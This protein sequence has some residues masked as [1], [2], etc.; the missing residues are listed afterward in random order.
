[1]KYVTPIFIKK[2]VEVQ[3]SA[4]TGLA[5]RTMRK[6]DQLSLREIARRMSITPAYLCDLERGNRN[7][8]DDLCKRFQKALKA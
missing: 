7:W 6:K 4:A 3:D 1:M 8:T 2:T 5:L